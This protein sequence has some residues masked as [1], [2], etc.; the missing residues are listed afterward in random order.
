[1]SLEKKN[2]IWLLPIFSGILV[3][4]ALPGQGLPNLGLGLL[5]PFALVPLFVGL[6]SSTR[7]LFFQTWLFGITVIALSFYWIT[8]PA[9]LFGGLSQS[10]TY[11]GYVVYCA[12]SGV[13][14]CIVL[15]PF[16]LDRMYF[17]RTG[18]L[19]PIATL[20]CASTLFELIVPRFF[21]WTLGS[22][23]SSSNSLNQWAAW[24]GFSVG[25]FFIFATG[26]YISRIIC[27]AQNSSER[28]QKTVILS[29]LTL[30][31]FGVGW[32]RLESLDRDIANLNRTRIGFIQPNFTFAELASNPVRSSDAQQQ[33]LDTLLRMSQEL[34]R[35]SNTKVDLIVWP[36]S[37]A[38][39]SFLFSRSQQEQVA[40]FTKKFETPVLLQANDLEVTDE[41][42]AYSVSTVVRVDGSIGPKYRKWVP[43]PFG[44]SIPFEQYVPGMGSLIR[45]T[46]GNM[47]KLG[48]GTS[49]AALE[50][51]KY[52]VGTFICFDAIYPDLARLQSL[53]GGASILINQA[54]FV[55]MGESNA[56]LYFKE[57][58]R[59]RAIENARSMLMV[60]NTGPTV[61]FDPTGREI[62]STTSLLTQAKSVAELPV[63]KSHTLY[64]RFGNLPWFILGAVSWLIIF[65]NFYRSPLTINNQRNNIF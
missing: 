8:Y 54:N 2:R 21:L 11:S 63:N 61:A 57:V 19:L 18:R 24:F 41:R 26:C 62:S 13:F 50:Y 28:I 47:S 36:E 35:E 10:V 23:M 12:L 16:V 27:Y 53:K 51:G 55:W 17:L 25:S 42:T 65:V 32:L 22:V 44:E 33:S 4:L 9:I 20:A 46:V 40:A 1:M 56:G 31:V 64:S 43:M 39:N 5:M 49:Y 48:I 45:S 37:V 29:A 38:P 30:V 14:F 3:A 6:Y 58:A 52:S 34:I 60:S 15:C 59:F 7:K